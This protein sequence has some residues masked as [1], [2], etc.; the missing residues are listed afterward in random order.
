MKEKGRKRNKS[1][2]LE[3]NRKYKVFVVTIKEVVSVIEILE[4]FSMLLG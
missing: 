3:E 2:K 4:L 1:T